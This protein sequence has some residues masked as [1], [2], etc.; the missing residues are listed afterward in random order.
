MTEMLAMTADATA[1]LHP[2]VPRQCQRRRSDGAGDGLEPLRLQAGRI[3]RDA[4]IDK[5]ALAVIDR[6]H[7]AGEGPEIIDRGL[8]AGVALLGTVAEPND[9]FG[10]VA[11][12]I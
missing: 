4:G 10:R 2:V 6:K 11:Q 3:D 8:R 9:P 1:M 12:M 5:R 7:L